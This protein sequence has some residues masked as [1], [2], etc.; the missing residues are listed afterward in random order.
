MAIFTISFFGDR[1]K[2]TIYNVTFSVVIGEFAAF[3]DEHS[4]LFC[5]RYLVGTLFPLFA[6]YLVVDNCYR[7]CVAQISGGRYHR[8]QGV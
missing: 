6:V 5:C 7:G 3:I 4:Q 2:R 1:K 8:V